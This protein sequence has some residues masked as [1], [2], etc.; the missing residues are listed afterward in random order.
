VTSNETVQDRAA[1][2]EKSAGTPAP[3]RA[4]RSLDRTLRLLD[5]GPRP[6]FRAAIAS[7]AGTSVLAM[8]TASLVGPDGPLL[9]PQR[10]MILAAL[11][12]LCL[13]A[14]L[15]IGSPAAGRVRAVARLDRL[16]GPQERAAVWLALAAWFPFLLA[17]VYYR[18]EATVPPSVQWAYFPFDDKRWIGA[19]YL[20]GALAP[21]L[22]V[23][24][25]ARVLAVGRDRP[26]T[27]RAW[28][29]GLFPRTAAVAADPHAG[30]RPPDGRG[31]PAGRWRGRAARLL[32][33][34]AGSVTAVALAWYFYGPPWYLGGTESPISMQEDVVLIGLQAVSRGHLPYIGVAGVQYGPGTQL[35]AYL[36]MDHVT[37][38]S[39]VGFREAWAL[40]QWAGASIL[41]AVF[42]LA[43]GYARGLA[44]SL[45]SALVYPGLNHIAFQP[46]G[47]F[48]GYWGWANPLRYV[49]VI[50]LVLLLPAVVRRSPSWRGAGAGAAVGALWGLTSY[51]AQENLLA[52]AVGGL[53][54]GGLLLFSGS[55]S[56]R[57]VRAALVAALAGFLLV[58]LP[59]LVFYAV[60]GHLGDFLDQ[61][62]LFPRA[63]AAGANNSPWLQPS[64]LT[65]MF[66]TLPFLL[67][68]LALPVAF[69]FRP[70]RIA[71]GWSRERIRLAVTVTATILLYQGA[72]LRSDPSHLTGTLLMVPALVIIT[73]TV[74]P[75]LVGARRRV[76][77]AIAGVA[78][79]VASFVLLPAE[80]FEAGGV[81]SAAGAPYADRERL[82]SG[83]RPG[84][85]ETP[86]GRRVGAGLDDAP[87]C[88]TGPPVPMAEFVE[89]MNRVHGIVGDRTAYVA[90]FPSAYPGLVYFVADLAPAPVSTD[91]YSS[92][93]TQPELEAFLDDVRVRVLPQTQVVLATSLD[94]PEARFFLQRYPT[95]RRI[96]LS[97]GGRPYY[98]LVRED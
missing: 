20:L 77:V 6:F 55:A 59:I 82:A 52:G 35:G 41:F 10:D 86:A 24:T 90:D 65:L 67:A 89:L 7:L 73:A 29:A 36:L 9:E 8:A 11:A 58:W 93:L 13:S 16:V 78:V 94:V 83:P 64:P 54:V 48:D 25:A 92:I 51:L 30:E 22:F 57:A 43:F 27:W 50:A 46:G 76:T 17:V 96:A 95:A 68:G 91:K 31:E 70:V 71:T 97:H 75:R 61:Y 19:A 60:R 4:A 32:P 18:A 12:A 40:F 45:L 62:F 2:A 63:V 81:R 49:G 80:A 5:E 87:V 74:L 33:V 66:Y 85:P 38:F 3:G 44:V 88:C 23:I 34:V 1:T 79:V 14:L 42:F 53:A 69:R 98:V 56:W 84:T 15:G 39:V 37:S 72:L 26:P 47:S 21:V 28:W